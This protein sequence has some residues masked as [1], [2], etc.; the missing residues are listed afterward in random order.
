MRGGA[1][2]GMQ[3]MS[4]LAPETEGASS[5]SNDSFVTALS[6]ISTPDDRPEVDQEDDSILFFKYVDDT[7][8]VERCSKDQAIRHVQASGSTEFIPA[9]GMNN[10]IDC[11]S[12]KAAAIDMKVNAKKT[13]LQSGP[14]TFL[15]L[16]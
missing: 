6:D 8:T 11:L 16:F 2:A 13:Q 15:S 14:L 7:T 10:L 5:V 9:V 3:L 12:G 4:L 1:D